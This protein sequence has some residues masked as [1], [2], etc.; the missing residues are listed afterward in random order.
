MSA[1]DFDFTS[2]NGTPLSLSRLEGYVVLI[3]NTA[4]QCGYTPQYASLQ[5]LWERYRNRGLVI[6]GIPSNDFGQQEPGDENAIRAFCVSNY[7]IGFPMT[8]K[9]SVIGDYAHPFYLWIEEEL[10]EGAGPRWN[11]HKYLLS[12]NGELT[13]S[14]PSDVDPL[15]EEIVLAIEEALPE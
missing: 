13:G 1:H 2:I 9:E 14:W 12:A 11:F 8:S 6:L 3:V 7:G 15:S 5:K 4:S 10:G